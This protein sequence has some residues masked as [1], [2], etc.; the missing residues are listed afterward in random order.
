MPPLKCP[1]PTCA[2]RFD[3]AKV[4][5]NAVLECPRCHAR[6]KLDQLVPSS[7]STPQPSRA[8]ATPRGHG[9][10]SYI[11]PVVGVMVLVAGLL[12]AVFLLAGKK[13]RPGVPNDI[14]SD[15]LNFSFTPPGG[16]W[17]NDEETKTNRLGVN[18]AA[19]RRT[20]PDAWVALGAKD[21]G[22]K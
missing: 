2:F 6:F 19:F 1:T 10:T 15:A 20:G 8:P 22:N 4:P 7:V 13:N 11:L 3:P 16:E 14:R 9:L 21:F 5:A 18:V 17:E 12:L